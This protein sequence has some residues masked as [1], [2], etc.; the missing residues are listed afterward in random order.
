MQFCPCL[1]RHK[2]TCSGSMLGGDAAALNKSCT[3]PELLSGENWSHF[4]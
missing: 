4:S 3:S 2:S 1:S